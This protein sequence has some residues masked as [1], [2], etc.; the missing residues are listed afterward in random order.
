MKMTCAELILLIRMASDFNGMSVEAR[1]YSGRNMY[2]A[3]CVGVALQHVGELF[4]LGAAMA[5]C[6]SDDQVEQLVEMS[7]VTDQLG[8]G[9]IAYW[10]NIEWDKSIVRDERED[11]NN[12]D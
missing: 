2:G 11:E 4:S 7:P 6:A 12:G 10:P 9:I 3:T 5:D 8:M 1:S